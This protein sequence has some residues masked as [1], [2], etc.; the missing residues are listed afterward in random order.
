MEKAW[1][2]LFYSLLATGKLMGQIGLIIQGTAPSLGKGKRIQ[3]S[4]TLLKNW[5]WVVSYHTEALKNSEMQWQPV[6]IKVYLQ[7]F[8]IFYRLNSKYYFSRIFYV[9]GKV[10]QSNE[11]CYMK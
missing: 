8:E 7:V 5:S 11:T 10:V 3:I 4:N 6:N 1:I 9:K 2:H